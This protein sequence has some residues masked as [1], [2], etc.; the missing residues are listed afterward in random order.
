MDV[1][2]DGLLPRW[3]S[4]RQGRV[5]IKDE[6]APLWWVQTRELVIKELFAMDEHE[7]YDLLDDAGREGEPFKRRT[8]RGRLATWVALPF[9]IIAV[10]YATWALSVG[11]QGES[12]WAQRF[13]DNAHKEIREEGKQEYLLGVGRADITG[14]KTSSS[15]PHTYDAYSDSS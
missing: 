1:K 4:R 7:K 14:Y 13:G 9:V 12:G 6:Q 15:K 3:G 5:G 11:L 2:L 8:R 10:I